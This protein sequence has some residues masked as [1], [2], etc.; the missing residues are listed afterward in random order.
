MIMSMRQTTKADFLCIKHQ[1]E[2]IPW[3]QKKCWDNPSVRYK[4]GKLAAFICI[5]RAHM[6]YIVYNNKKNLNKLYSSRVEASSKQFRFDKR[7]YEEMFPLCTS[8]GG[9]SWWILNNTDKKWQTCQV[10]RSCLSSWEVK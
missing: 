5:L 9:M 1:S 2:R 6:Y 8:W 7:Q 4:L 10:V 3:L